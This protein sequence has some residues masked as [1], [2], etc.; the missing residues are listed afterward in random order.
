MITFYIKGFV[1]R[2]FTLTRGRSVLTM[3]NMVHLLNVK[4]KVYFLC[5]YYSN[6]FSQKQKLR[7]LRL[8]KKLL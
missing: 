7:K 5:M 3:T 6:K 2:D 4:V 1:Q 8:T